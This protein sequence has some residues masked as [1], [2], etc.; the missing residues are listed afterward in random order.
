MND[1]LNRQHNRVTTGRSSWVEFSQKRSRFTRSPGAYLTRGLVL[2]SSPHWWA[3][4]FFTSAMYF[5]QASLLPG[6][7]C[8]KDQ[9]LL[10][11]VRAKRKT[12]ACHRLPLCPVSAS[13]QLCRSLGTPR[14]GASP[15]GLGDRRLKPLQ[16]SLQAD[17]QWRKLHQGRGATFSLLLHHQWNS[18]QWGAFLPV[19]AFYWSQ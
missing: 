11:D 13:W 7:A 4:Y 15:P 8:R 16:G 3:L 1:G 9:K 19:D 2:S 6:S 14:L 12:P 10:R 18:H 17:C 5:D